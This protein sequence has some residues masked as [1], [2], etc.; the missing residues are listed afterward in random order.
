MGADHRERRVESLQVVGSRCYRKR[1]AEAKKK[2]VTHLHTRRE[3]GSTLGT[4]RRT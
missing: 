2:C 4:G 1:R 3:R